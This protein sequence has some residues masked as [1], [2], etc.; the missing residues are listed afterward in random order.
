MENR[1]MLTL[2]CY[3]SCFPW[4]ERNLKTR[5]FHFTFN[6]NFCRFIHKIL[7]YIQIGRL[8]RAIRKRLQSVFGLNLHR[9]QY[10]WKKRTMFL[11]PSTLIQ[12]SWV[13]S[14]LLFLYRGSEQQI[15][16]G[17]KNEI[18]NLFM[19]RMKINLER[20]KQ[21]DIIQI[22]RIYQLADMTFNQI[23]YA[24]DFAC[25]SFFCHL[26]LLSKSAE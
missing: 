13:I 22:I 14:P 3:K 2:G 17:K 12:Y 6:S 10:L 4:L 18:W 15:T 26:Q 24:M 20:W 7:T 11:H 25:I 5:T 21:S 8:K 23:N 1:H 16:N 19:K 9:N